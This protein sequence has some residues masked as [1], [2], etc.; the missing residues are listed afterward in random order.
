MSELEDAL[1]NLQNIPGN[2]ISG[3]NSG[4]LQWVSHESSERYISE[5]SRSFQQDLENWH[6]EE[7]PALDP[8][9][10]DVLRNAEKE[11][12]PIPRSTAKQ[13]ISHINKFKSFLQSHNLST[14]IE[15]IPDKY[16]ND[17]LS[18]FFYNLK[19]N[20]DKLYSP[21]SLICFRA[22]IQ[23]YLSGP[24]VNRKIDIIN[25]QTFS[26]SN[27]ILKLQVGKWLKENGTEN[28]RQY[29]AIQETDMKLLQSFF[30]KSTPTVLQ[31]ECCFNIVYYFGFRGRETLRDLTIS[32]IGFDTDASGRRYMYIKDNS[33]SKNVKASL[34]LKEFSNL[35]QQGCMQRVK[36]TVPLSQWS[37]T[38]KKYLPMSVDYFLCP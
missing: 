7:I 24:E 33:L 28:R 38:L 23:R 2:M 5:L 11:S 14:H 10:S 3:M 6:A 29:E 9:I 30:D 34:S 32:S 4:D 37:S 8:D 27:R 20:E 12:R 31:L 18:F 16:L 21:S 17:Y 26:R 25:D 1:L 15:T 19:T 13:T 36:E 35:K 22:S